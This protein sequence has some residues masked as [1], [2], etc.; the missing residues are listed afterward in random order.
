M[1]TLPALALRARELSRRVEALPAEVST[2]RNRS[3]NELDMNVHFSQLQALAIFVDAL[4]SK[5]R[6]LLDALDPE[7]EPGAFGSTGLQLI[8]E[9]IKSQRMWDFFRDKLEL[10]F[11]P[12]FKEVL[13]TAD[14]IAWD[15]YRPVMDEAVQKGILPAAEIRE[16]PLTYLVAEFSPATWVRRSRPFDGRDYALGTATLP[17][18]VI[19]IPWD[20]VGNL[21][22]LVSLQHEVGHDLEADLKLRPELLLSINRVL[23]S[24]GVPAQRIKV[25]QA[26][27][28]ETLAD[29]IGLQ[30]GG[31]AFTQG[32]M[33][34][35][36]LPTQMVVTYDPSDPHPTHYV[37][38][39]MNAAYI[40][41]LIPGRQELSDDAEAIK[42]TW[43]ALYG[44]PD[45]FASFIG[46]FPHVFTALMDSPMDALGGSTLRDLLPYREEDDTRV[47]LAAAYLRTGMNAPTPLSM[48]P[49]HCV[50]AARLAATA[51][52]EAA[53]ADPAADVAD[54]LDKINDRLGQ[55]VRSMALPG[56]RAGD[57][58]DP[59]KRFIAGFAEFV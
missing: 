22:E 33:H 4:V 32:L 34:L 44:P 31:P 55:M 9:I 51:V 15:C 29:L 50:S 23:K 18:P 21:W 30:L 10:R 40:R 59:H 14:T 49:R 26:W 42:A 43:Q 38:I 5:Q 35:L 27:E 41:T 8:N 13:W 54:A 3:Q 7:A 52:V 46:D 24:Q 11:S 47:R 45:T 17:I 53:R 37:R 28:G 39:L 36:I 57:I 2:W 48:R 19:E 6:A 25:W 20:H 16:P 58:S 1:T 56:L 12:D